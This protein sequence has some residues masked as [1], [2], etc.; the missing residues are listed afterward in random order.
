MPRQ[1]ANSSGKQGDPFLPISPIVVGRGRIYTAVEA[2]I[3]TNILVYRYDW[4]FPEKQ[5]SATELLRQGAE[6]RT[7]CLPHQGLIEFVAATTR[8]QRSLDGDALLSRPEAYREAEELLN[9][10]IV[11]YPTEEVLMTAF[12]GAATYQLS[13]FDAH[14][15]AYAEVYGLP[16]I[17]TEDFQH[18]R[19]YG[20][21]RTT[22]PFA[23]ETIHEP[24]PRYG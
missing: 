19:L 20:T 23:A 11:L 14:L 8:A 2:L 9:T 3:D 16:E 24:A 22:N 17:L 13:W 5:R 12:R 15:W 10:F 4:R 18:G 6:L 7:A 21:V 1:S